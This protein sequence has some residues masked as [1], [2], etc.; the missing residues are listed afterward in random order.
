MKR[1][2][3]I[4]LIFALFSACGDEADPDPVGRRDV[5]GNGGA[6]SGVEPPDTRSFVVDVIEGLNS[7]ALVGD[8][9]TARV[10]PSGRPAVAYGYY[11]DTTETRREIHLAELQGD[12]SWATEVV[13]SP[14]RDFPAAAEEKLKGLGFDFVDG[15]PHI[16]YIGGDDDGHPAVESLSDLALSVRS[17]GSWSHQLLSE[18]SAEATGECFDESN[19]CVQGVTV[20]LWATLR[21]GPGAG[22]FAIAH[23]DEHFLG[24]GSEDSASADLELYEAPGGRKVMVDGGRSAGNRS[25]LAYLADGRLAVAYTLDEPA[26][27][28]SV[29]VAV[30]DG[31]GWARTRVS[32]HTARHRLSL[33]A[34]PDGTLWLAYYD[35]DS[36]DLVVA[37]SSDDG[38]TWDIERVDE[39]G[40]V[41]LHPSLAVADDGTVFVAY[42]YCGNASDRD[43][44]GSLGRDS[45]VRLATRVPGATEWAI[46]TID[47]GQGQGFVG[48][49]NSLVVLPDDSLGVAF[50][51]QRNSDLL[52]ARETE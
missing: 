39:R 49:F 3:P 13:V 40:D 18:S 14:A 29:W 2:L 10:S 12:L 26:D 30:E 28:V 16:A 32:E 34:A 11:L 52:F 21:A 51:D 19:Y 17:G 22:Q 33:E 43:C 36:V 7:S 44:P 8:F 4:G 42:T 23:R 41:G 37:S 9:A 46:Q 6:D 50:V 15:A 35:A 24:F 27:L 31:D 48:E 20:G 45:V 38:E 5:G 1:A 47:D 25:A